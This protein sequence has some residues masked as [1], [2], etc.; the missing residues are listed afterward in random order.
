MK[1]IK[2]T[3]G[4]R[5]IVDDEDYEY[6]NQFKWRFSSNGY[7][8]TSVKTIGMHRLVN[9]TPQGLDTDHINGNKLDNR[10]SNL[11]S[12]TRSQNMLNVKPQTNNTSGCTGV[13]K[14]GD[15]WYARI[16]INRKERWL[17]SFNTFHKAVRARRSAERDIYV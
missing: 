16:N 3:K 5:A 15:K 13:G 9:N 8:N 10:R 14:R 6:L 2:L 1:Y 17:G 4:K 12:V 11:R 7:A